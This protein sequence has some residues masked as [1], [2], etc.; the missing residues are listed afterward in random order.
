MPFTS[1]A[2][3]QHYTSF[4]FSAQRQERVRQVEWDKLDFNDVASIRAAREAIT[5]MGWLDT[6]CDRLFTNSAKQRALDA[7][8]TKVLCEKA[9]VL[10][11]DTQTLDDR[12]LHII[13]GSDTSAGGTALER[14]EA[15]RIRAQ[16][17]LM[18]ML[19]PEGRNMYGSFPVCAGSTVQFLPDDFEGQ[20]DF[21]TLSWPMAKNDP[22][23]DW[24]INGDSKAASTV[25]CLAMLRISHAL[26]AYSAQA[27]DG[28]VDEAAEDIAAQG[29]WLTSVPEEHRAAVLAA[30]DDKDHPFL[31]RALTDGKADVVT[32][33]GGLLASVPDIQRVDFVAARDANGKLA[34]LRALKAL[35]DQALDA[36]VRLY[37]SLLSLMP[38]EDRAALLSKIYKDH[39][40]PRMPVYRLRALLGDPVESHRNNPAHGI[41]IRD[42]RLGYQATLD[43][44]SNAFTT[45]SPLPSEGYVVREN[46]QYQLLRMINPV[47]SRLQAACD[48]VMNDATT[49]GKVQILPV[50][51]KDRGWPLEDHMVTLVCAPGRKPLIIDS[52]RGGSYPDGVDVV[53]TGRQWIFDKVSCGWHAV[54]QCVHYAYMMDQGVPYDEIRPYGTAPTTH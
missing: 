39:D 51:V 30:A 34:L 49:T 38:D 33:Y 8:A 17:K 31:V 5:N 18:D 47:L 29:A 7:F 14:V 41:P 40:D 43:T 26:G 9:L 32:A 10:L 48:H 44:L 37:A 50:G 35:P 28:S 16:C 25:G 23:L 6:L 24:V 15:A 42:V 3:N 4:T 53:V 13:V 46:H 12:V 36:T 11:D 20:E 45:D 1:S 19:T 2:T 21:L 22:R 52:K 27:A 54:Q